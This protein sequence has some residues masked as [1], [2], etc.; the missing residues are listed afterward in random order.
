MMMGAVTIWQ[1]RVQAFSVA[2]NNEMF[3][4]YG[5]CHDTWCLYGDWG[6]T[7]CWQ[8]EAAAAA[9]CS[10]AQYTGGCFY[11]EDVYWPAYGCEVTRQMTYTI[12]HY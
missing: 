4:C 9:Y 7:D 12:C 11:Y 3:G 1:A 6:P 10:G 5:S 8:A 2:A